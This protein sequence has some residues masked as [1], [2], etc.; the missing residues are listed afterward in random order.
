M[1]GVGTRVPGLAVSG[2]ECA[3]SV[4][5]SEGRL[6]E[7]VRDVLD[8]E[9]VDDSPAVRCQLTATVGAVLVAV[10]EPTRPA[11][12]ESAVVAVAGGA[13]ARPIA[14]AGSTHLDHLEAAHRP[15]RGPSAHCPGHAPRSAPS[16]LYRGTGG[17]SGVVRR[18]TR[19]WR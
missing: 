15:L 4:R 3:L 14:Q 19:G 8:H 6:R 10:V 1:V 9:F 16:S 11:V 7:V 17:R 5:R 18:G 13:G 12:G 2:G